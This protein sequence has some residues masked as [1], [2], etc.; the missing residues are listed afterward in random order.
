MNWTGQLHGLVNVSY[1]QVLALKK[2]GGGGGVKVLF[3]CVKANA[4]RLES[5]EC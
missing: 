4:C 3:F 2:E 1:N 5:L